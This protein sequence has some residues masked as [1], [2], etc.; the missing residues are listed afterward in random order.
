MLSDSLSQTDT[1][2]KDTDFKM[3]P[4]AKLKTM[5]RYILDT[6]KKITQVY[7]KNNFTIR[8]QFYLPIQLVL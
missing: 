2:T 3:P 8:K 1:A 4:L 6:S 7:F 5:Q